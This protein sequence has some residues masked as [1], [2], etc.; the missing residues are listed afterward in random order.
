MPSGIP[1]N[2]ANAEMETH[3]VTAEMKRRKCSK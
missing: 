2:E 1:T 3:P